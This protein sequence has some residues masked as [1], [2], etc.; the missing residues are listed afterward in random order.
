MAIKKKESTK[1]SNHKKTTFQFSA[2]EA[3][4]VLLAGDFNNW[5]PEAHPL[6][7]TSNGMWKISVSLSPGRYEYKYLV[8]GEW[9]NDPGCESIA[10]NPFG[11][12]NCV[13]TLK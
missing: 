5:N 4:H 9:H 13:I 12:S 3:Q 8:D 2:P 11:G 1:K 6:Q 10:P 7:R